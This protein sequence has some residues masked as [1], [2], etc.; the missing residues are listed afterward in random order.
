MLCR[1]EY[2]NSI[3]C[4]HTEFCGWISLK[5]FAE[6]TLRLWCMHWWTRCSQQL[7]TIPWMRRRIMQGPA[8]TFCYYF[9]EKGWSLAVLGKRKG[10]AKK[11]YIDERGCQGGEVGGRWML[12]YGKASC[13]HWQSM[14]ASNK[15]VCVW[16]CF[17]DLLGSPCKTSA[18]L[19]C[20]EPWIIRLER[21]CFDSHFFRRYIKRATCIHKRYLFCTVSFL[22][23]Q[24]MRFPVVLCSVASKWLRKSLYVVYLGRKSE[25]YVAWLDFELPFHWWLT[26]VW[27]WS[28]SVT[29]VFLFLK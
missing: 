6:R 4:W 10:G 2:R 21:K 1:L 20:P 5:E 24:V 11:G 9:F 12:N 17:A 23:C 14:L 16:R 19:T 29:S 8:G 3:V 26:L 22:S 28:K 27:N 13:V 7:G 15:T 25:V 18:T